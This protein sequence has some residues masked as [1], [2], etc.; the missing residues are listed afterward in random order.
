MRAL[1]PR[2]YL[3]YNWSLH[4]R[5]VPS[6]QLPTSGS[7]ESDFCSCEF[8]IWK[9][10]GMKDE[11]GR[12]VWL[13]D[14]KEGRKTWNEAS[15]VWLML[16][17]SDF[18]LISSW[19]LRGMWY[20]DHPGS[21]VGMGFRSKSRERALARWL[22]WLGTITYPKRLWVQFR[23]GHTLGLR[24]PSPGW[25]CTGRH[26]PIFFSLIDVLEWKSVEERSQND[27]QV[28]GLLCGIQWLVL[29]EL[30]WRNKGTRKFR[31]EGKMIH[32]MWPVL[33]LNVMWFT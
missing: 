31:A 11:R 14:S 2:S 19:V 13:E 16:R 27:S 22:R 7:H 20:I 21:G 5:A 17:N 24:I 3:S 29:D 33:A 4:F 15:S 12:L 8:G 23:S 30:S 6:P 18:I 26:L 32:L 25:A 1:H 9:H 10:E 28:P